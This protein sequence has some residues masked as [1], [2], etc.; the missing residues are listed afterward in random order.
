M[1]KAA[2][3]LTFPSDAERVGD[4]VDVV[5]PGRDQRDLQDAAIVEADGAQ[6]LV[7]RWRNARGILRDLLDI[8]EHDTVLLRQV[9]GTE[10]GLEG[11]DEVL[12]QCDP[13]QKL[14]VRLQSILATIGGRDDRRDHLVLASRQRQIRRH[15]RPER[16]ERVKH[17]VGNQ[18]V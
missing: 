13:T 17:R 6:S 15:Q 14:C 4:A 10:V 8:L 2:E 11:F 12:V 7:E 3:W 5:E 1:T 16:R 18:R 9:D